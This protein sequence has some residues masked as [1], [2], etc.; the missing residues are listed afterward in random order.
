MNQEMFRCL[1]NMVLE[2]QAAISADTKQ[3]I[4]RV[5]VGAGSGALI[6]GGLG[7][8]NARHSAYTN[9]QLANLR[10]GTTKEERDTPE[11]KEKVRKIKNKATLTGGLVGG[12]I[13]GIYGGYAGHEYHKIKGM[14]EA[15]KK[16]WGNDSWRSYQRNSSG[17]SG[18]YSRSGS[19]SYSSYGSSNNVGRAKEVFKKHVGTD[20]SDV[21][22]KAEAQKIYR[23]AAKKFHPDVNPGGDAA[24]KDLNGA[25]DTLRESSW[26][27]KLAM[28]YE[29]KMRQEMEKQAAIGAILGKALPMATKALG[30]VKASGIGQKAI[31][32]AAQNPN[33]VKGAVTGSA[34]GGAAGAGKGY[35]KAKDEGKSG[36]AGGIKGALGGAAVGGLAGGAAGFG[37]SK[38]NTKVTPAAKPMKAISTGLDIASAMPGSSNREKVAAQN[39]N[40]AI[41]GTIRG[42]AMGG[43]GKESLGVGGKPLKGRSG[44][45]EIFLRQELDKIPLGGLK[46]NVHE[47]SEKNQPSLEKESA[48]KEEI[49]RKA[50]EGGVAGAIGGGAYGLGKGIYKG[51]KKGKA[52]G[53]KGIAEAAKEGLKG[54]GTGTLTGAALGAG[55]G[56]IQAAT[57][58]IKQPKMKKFSKSAAEKVDT[59]EKNENLTTELSDPGSVRES[60]ILTEPENSM[61]EQLV[62]APAE[63]S[64]LENIHTSG[65][66]AAKAEIRESS[67][68]TRSVLPKG[69]TAGKRRMQRK[70]ASDLSNEFGLEERQTTLSKVA[71]PSKNLLDAME[72]NGEYDDIM[73]EAETQLNRVLGDMTV[74]DTKKIKQKGLQSP[75]PEEAVKETQPAAPPELTDAESQKYSG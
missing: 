5:L 65:I 58:G 27:Q 11:F 31:T 22:T 70:L 32:F 8:I 41:E 12:A 16:K 57:K 64:G 6:S 67:K 52:K 68:G 74:V 53:E 1:D 37:L 20:F 60:I 45:A 48:T 44:N 73:K 18:S 36:L 2:K 30:A 49:L 34:L 75:T 13:G 23:N 38:M 33:V 43:M 25:W 61:T 46:S 29:E 3:H 54:L 28:M 72:A 15:Y 21:T 7:A 56:A 42:S 47:A 62:A 14:E 50:V 66:D 51:Y 35:Q 40:G 71:S 39:F 9:T 17:G 24:M 10:K 19:G 26:F 69:L 4:K 59:T 55:T 63:S